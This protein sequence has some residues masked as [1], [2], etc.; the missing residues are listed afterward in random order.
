[1]RST[2]GKGSCF[3]FEIPVMRAVSLITPTAPDDDQAKLPRLNILVVE[4]NAVNRDVARRFLE[5]LGQQVTLVEDGA[6][7][8]RLATSER[9][10]LVLMDMQ[11]PVMDGIAATREIRAIEAPDRRNRIVAMTANASDNDRAEC[12]SAGMDGFLSKPV[13]RL[14]LA[15][16]IR[17]EAALVQPATAP[18]GAPSPSVDEARRG[19]LAET[20]GDD[21]LLALDDSFFAE[22]VTILRD[23]R[24][25]LASG[26]HAATDR[27]L[28]TIKGSASNLGYAELARC[29]E[30]ARAAPQ[31]G[32]VAAALDHR[33]DEIRGRAAQAA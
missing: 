29:A 10:D 31:D 21:G 4:D 30:A 22:A 1:M 24:A 12:L 32:D 5:R 23:L 17:A 6:A 28:H 33:L 11:M 14:R 27:A 9:F 20:F 18:V 26:D 25:A 19:E 3:W 2:P 8:V 16:L 7:G 15:E 13:S